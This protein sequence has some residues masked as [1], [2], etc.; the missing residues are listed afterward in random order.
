MMQ[1]VTATHPQSVIEKAT[2]SA[3]QVME[4]GNAGAYDQAITWLQQVKNAYLANDQAD[5]WVQYRVEIKV[6]HGRNRKLMTLLKSA[7]L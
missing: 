4:A 6:K 1:T 5:K 3:N 2:I 7:E